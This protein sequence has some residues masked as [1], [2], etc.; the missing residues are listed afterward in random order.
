MEK[1]Y[2][3]IIDNLFLFLKKLENN[4]FKC[5]GQII[6][7]SDFIN[8]IEELKSF[9]NKQKYAN[10]DYIEFRQETNTND[11][12]KNKILIIFLSLILG[13]PLSVLLIKFYPYFRK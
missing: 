7:I 3:K 5:S 8:L 10:Y 2:Q 6:Y 9:L 4:E 11:S 1:F 13:F 12:I